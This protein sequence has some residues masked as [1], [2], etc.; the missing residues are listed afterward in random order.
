MISPRTIDRLILRLDAIEQAQHT[1]ISL[2]SERP[3]DTVRAKEA[4]QIIGV[5]SLVTLLKKNEEYSLGGVQHGKIWTWS[6]A[7]LM[8][9]RMTGEG[10]TVVAKLRMV[11]RGPRPKEA[12]L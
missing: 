6:R 12:D 7:K 2:L 8:A 1:I 5:K 10:N 11:R 4:M 9:W 3:D